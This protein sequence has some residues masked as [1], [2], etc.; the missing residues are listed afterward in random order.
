MSLTDDLSLGMER[1]AEG[2]WAAAEDLYRR[3]LSAAESRGALAPGPAFHLARLLVSRG[4]ERAPEA[5]RALRVATRH[6]SRSEGARWVRPSGRQAPLTREEVDL[7]A[8]RHMLAQ[9]E[10]LPKAERRLL[11]WLRRNPPS[12]AAVPQG[13]AEALALL[14]L[15]RLKSARTDEALALLSEAGAIMQQN[16]EAADQALLLLKVGEG[17]VEHGVH[18]EAVPFIRA[19]LLDAVALGHRRLEDRAGTALARALTPLQAFAEAQ[20]LLDHHRPLDGE[21]VREHLLAQLLLTQEQA[22][23]DVRIAELRSRDHPEELEGALGRLGGCPP[24]AVRLLADEQDPARRAHAMLAWAE[25]QA[26]LAREVGHEQELSEARRL[27]EA[28]RHA[29]ATALLH[30]GQG[31]AEALSRELAEAQ[32]PRGTLARWVEAAR[33]HLQGRFD[34]LRL[35]IELAGARALQDELLEAHGTLPAG[36]RCVGRVWPAHE[37]FGDF[38]LARAEGERLDVLV[39]DATG[40]GANAMALMV[41]LLAVVREE[42]ATWLSVEDAVRALERVVKPATEAAMFA[43]LAWLRA[44]VPS[45]RARLYRFGDC[46]ALVQP[47][48][49]RSWKACER[50]NPF[51]GLTDSVPTLRYEDLDLKPGSTVL[52]VSDGCVDQPNL[53]GRHFG[54]DGLR[55]A[56]RP[57]LDPARLDLSL[58]TLHSAIQRHSGT[59]R[60]TDDQ[61]AVLLSVVGGG[62]V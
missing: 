30:H 36:W 20:S 15:V 47:A 53:E 25:A 38:W 28:A 55:H 14:G 31:R 8:C 21:V 46:Q 42:L 58:D 26:M 52:L 4:R 2:A 23:E 39:A 13:A 11:A 45:G 51:L 54:L 37:T 50:A 41:Q 57:G 6:V 17:L 1:E 33:P 3:A 60:A 9:P 32:R 12:A 27:V 7:L 61:T 56:L 24:L 48:P 59:R 18:R 16:G 22:M 10:G 5:A 62:A 44:D 34:A 43:S 29:C 35:K 49:G 19:A 40:H